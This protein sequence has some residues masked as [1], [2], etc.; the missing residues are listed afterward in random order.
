M[1]IGDQTHTGAVSSGSTRP[2]YADLQLAAGSRIE[3]PVAKE[4]SAL[5]YL[6]EGEAD[7]LAADEQ[8]PLPL[9]A[10]SLLGEGDRVVIEAGDQPCRILLIAGQPIRE[11]VAQYGPFVMNTREELE[12]ALQDFREGRLTDPAA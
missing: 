2:L 9:H 6:Y 11:P 4:L 8:K 3:L 7:L 10:A 5:L 12:Q 1:C